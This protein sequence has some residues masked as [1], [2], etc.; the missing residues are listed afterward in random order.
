MGSC[1]VSGIEV[2]LLVAASGEDWNSG[3]QLVLRRPTVLLEVVEL[4]AAAAGN[5]RLASASY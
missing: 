4:A 3:S 5:R 1:K 2:M